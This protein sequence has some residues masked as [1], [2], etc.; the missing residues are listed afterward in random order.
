[1]LTLPV[2]FKDTE[3]H[4]THGEILVSPAPTF[5]QPSLAATTKN[6]LARHSGF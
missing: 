6:S 5:S 3:V 1:M 4:R 2:D